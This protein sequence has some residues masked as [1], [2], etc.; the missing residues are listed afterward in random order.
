[1]NNQE[2]KELKRKLKTLK[3]I[4]K[5]LELDLKYDKCPEII[6]ISTDALGA[7]AVNIQNWVY[8]LS[9]VEK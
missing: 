9:Q 6:K 7:K 8:D 2:K 4:V 3:L 1:M 5:E